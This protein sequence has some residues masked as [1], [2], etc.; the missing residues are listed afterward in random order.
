MFAF[1][2]IAELT[3]PTLADPWYKLGCFVDDNDRNLKYGPMEYGYSVD[4]CFDACSSYLYF[5][6]QNGG[7]CSCGAYNST[8]EE[9]Y[10]VN[11]SECG[12]DGLGGVSRNM[13]YGKVSAITMNWQYWRCSGSCFFSGGETGIGIVYA[14]YSYMETY[15]TFARPLTLSFEMK[16]VDSFYQCGILALFPQ[17]FKR[18]TGYTTGIQ[19]WGNRFGFALN[20]A[21]VAASAF[22]Y[23]SDYDWHKITIE[24]GEYQIRAYYDDVL[25]KILYDTTYM[26]GK[27]RIGYNCR[28][29]AY[30]NFILY[31]PTALPT[32][33]PT[34]PPTEVP[35]L[36]PTSPTALPTEVPTIS[37]TVSP[38]VMPTVG[39]D[40]A[41]NEAIDDSFSVFGM[42]V[43]RAVGE[44]MLIVFVI[45]LICVWIPTMI[46][47]YCLCSG[48]RAFLDVRGADCELV[49]IEQKYKLESTP[50][51][52]DD[53]NQAGNKSNGEPSE[54]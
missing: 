26:S 11:A 7:L 19:W 34:I 33:V 25:Q 9:N 15:A 13:V 23:T 1:L 22:G 54:I 6:L 20:T 43:S 50:G 24:A 21:T 27:I 52:I 42:T 17:A 30:R 44:G 29:Y 18:H 53:I 28:D 8:W 51:D 3:V 10:K 47:C 41:A 40:T 39:E 31:T 49:A 46:V 16:N 48:K 45:I 32:E 36:P 38:T 2:L 14:G 4:T 35:T 37:P 5:A 12:S